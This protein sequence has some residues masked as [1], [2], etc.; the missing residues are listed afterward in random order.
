MSRASIAQSATLESA[1]DTGIDTEPNV[2][3]NLMTGIIT[4]TSISVIWEKPDGNAS[5]YEIQILGEPTFNKTVATTSNTIGG[6]TPGNYYTLLVT[7]VVGEYN[8]TG[9]S[10]EISVNTKPA[11][12]K[13]LMTGIITTTSISLT[14]EEPV[15]NASSYEIQILGNPTFNKTVASTI[16]TLEGLTPGNYY[17]LLVTAMVGENNVSG[18]SSVISVYTSTATLS[19][20]AAIPTM[21]RIAAASLFGRWRAV[22]QTALQRPTMPRPESRV[23][24]S[25]CAFRL[26]GAHSQSR[27]AQRRGQTAVGP[28]TVTEL[29]ASII[30]SS[31][32]YVSWLLPQGNRSSYLVDVIGDPP[33]SFT[34]LSESVIITNLHFGNQYTLRITAV[35]GNGLQGGNKELFILDTGVSVS[36]HENPKSSPLYTPTP[37]PPKPGQEDQQMEPQAPRISATMTYGIRYGWKK[38]LEGSNEKTQD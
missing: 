29:K 32:I 18:N 9:S 38:N 33:Q 10:L 2:V 25:R 1:E 4:I 34:V 23:V 14:W 37:P 17:T 11:I 24:T 36:K 27:E 26:P 21:I 30:N 7:A 20:A 15:G 8:V 6:L 12:V 16:F 3:K 35:A 19:D 13:N 22:T 5:S 31:T 28:A